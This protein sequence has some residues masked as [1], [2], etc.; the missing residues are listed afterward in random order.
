MSGGKSSSWWN[1]TPEQHHE[2]EGLRA[3]FLEYQ[4]RGDAEDDVGQGEDPDGDVVL[5]PVQVQ[6]FLHALDLRVR[7]VGPAGVV[8]CWRC[9]V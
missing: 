3:V 4:V 1:L 2:A 7:D 9:T 6:V 8:N 5:V